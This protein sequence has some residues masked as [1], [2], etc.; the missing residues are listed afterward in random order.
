[1]GREGWEIDCPLAFPIFCLPGAVASLAPQ[2]SEQISD[3]GS[4]SRPLR[5]IGAVGAPSRQGAKK[6][7]LC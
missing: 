7:A 4:Q 1:M 6:P 5:R 2:D 3:G